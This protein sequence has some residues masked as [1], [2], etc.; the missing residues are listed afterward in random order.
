[1]LTGVSPTTNNGQS[2]V[3]VTLTGQL[4]HFATG[5]TKVS[6]ARSA[7]QPQGSTISALPANAALQGMMAGQT[8]PPALQ[9]GPV[10][11]T[12]ATHLTVPVTMTPATAAGSYDITVTTPVSSGTETLTLKNVFTV[13]T[14]PSFTGVNITPGATKN[15]GSSTPPAPTSATY[16]A[17]IVGLFCIKAISSNDAVYAGAV[18]RQYDR[19]NNQNTMFTNLN[20]WVYG[21]IN[22]LIDQRKQA[23]TRG[24]LGGIG[25]GDF[26][27]TGFLPGIRDTQ[28]TPQVNNLLPLTL[29]EGPLTDGVDA[30]VISPS[31]WINYGDN[32]L[33]VT[34]NHNQDS[35]TNSIFTDGRVTNQISTQTLGPIVIGPAANVAGSASQAVINDA[36]TAV[37]DT[38][39]V[40]PFVE[41]QGP[42]HDRPVGLAD[43]AVDITASTILPNTTLVLTREIIEKRLGAGS[44][45]LMTIEL[46]DTSHGFTG[47]IGADRPGHYQ[48]FIQIERTSGSGNP[49][50]PAGGA[51]DPAGA[52]TNP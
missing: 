1:M 39:L 52:G 11:A 51:A 6:F 38:I 45:T 50:A 31:L 7:T 41:L 44:W 4:T 21:D 36:A 25:N 42:T 8:S 17:V 29:W 32:P 12:T 24:P 47:L 10:Q 20:T 3:N 43:A 48:M 23:G 46:N 22:G 13:T 26:V 15:A 27:P 30:L 34:W 33:F 14:V 35:F 5:S 19:R 9:A 49:T 2:N 28:P 37:L 18:V 40:I 16:R